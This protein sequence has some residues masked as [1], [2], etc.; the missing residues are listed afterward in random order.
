MQASSQVELKS[1]GEALGGSKRQLSSC[2]FFPPACTVGPTPEGEECLG[3]EDTSTGSRWGG[4][5][6]GWLSDSCSLRSPAIEVLPT[7]ACCCQAYL[8]MPPEDLQQ[9]VLSAEMEAAQG[10]LTLMHRSWAQLKVGREG[11]GT[12]IDGI[13]R[14]KAPRP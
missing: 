1:L 14:S 5:G 8:H 3:P 6:Y 11:R 10:F 4:G 2:I 12:R 9:L 7:I 13:K